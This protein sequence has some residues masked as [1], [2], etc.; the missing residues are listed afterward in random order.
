MDVVA[1]FS[2]L[3]ILLSF[4]NQ[5]TTRAFWWIKGDDSVSQLSRGHMS[6]HQPWGGVLSR[7]CQV[8]STRPAD[9]YQGHSYI[10]ATLWLLKL[11]CLQ[12]SLFRGRKTIDCSALLSL[13]P[14][15]LQCKK[16]GS[17]RCT[18]IEFLHLK[19][20]KEG[21]GLRFDFLMVEKIECLLQ[22][23]IKTNSSD[24]NQFF[25]VIRP[26]QFSEKIR[27]RKKNNGNKGQ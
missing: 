5:V 11:L 13:T 21:M 18:A 14:R 16:R 24:L 25:K 6:S 19:S 2:Q 4:I 20:E 10:L 7:Q 27:K 12:W 15:P 9:P 3:F 17:V 23:Q 26:S 22:I 1:C 8:L